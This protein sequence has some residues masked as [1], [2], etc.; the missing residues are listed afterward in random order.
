MRKYTRAEIHTYGNTDT[1]RQIS[2]HT[3][4][5]TKHTGIHRSIQE[6]RHPLHTYTQAGKQAYIHA[7]RHTYNI[8]TYIH[9][10]IRTYIHT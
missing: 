1:C 10:A 3:N 8:Q 9:A 2:I 4:I 6:G 7:G 5:E